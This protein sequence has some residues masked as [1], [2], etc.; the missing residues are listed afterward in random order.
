MSF[1]RFVLHGKI[2]QFR[3]TQV[4]DETKHVAS[5]M[6]LRFVVM[7]KMHCV[8]MKQR[9]MFLSWIALLAVAGTG[10]VAGIFVI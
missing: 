2:L 7:G 6:G 10:V 1:Q 4:T 9:C 5:K 3:K 8:W